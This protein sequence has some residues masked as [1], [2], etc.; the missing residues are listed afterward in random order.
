[1]PL[2]LMI[3]FVVD[4]AVPNVP[5]TAELFYKQ[6]GF[7]AFGVSQF[8]SVG[9][10]IATLN[11]C[12]TSS[13]A[14]SEYASLSGTREEWEHT[15]APD[16]NLVILDRVSLEARLLKGTI[17]YDEAADEM[18]VWVPKVHEKI[19]RARRSEA[20]WWWAFFC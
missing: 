6:N 8:P 1:M 18:K 10:G 11:E 3:P 9:N 16:E 7:L 4:G 20:G 5:T 15:F 14:L 12:T 19:A 17:A 2:Y 13:I